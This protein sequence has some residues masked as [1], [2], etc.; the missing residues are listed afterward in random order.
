MLEKN[1]NI[2]SKTPDFI[3]EKTPVSKIPDE[4]KDYYAKYGYWKKG[5][6]FSVKTIKEIA[7]ILESGE[8]PTE[9]PMEYDENM[10]FDMLSPHYPLGRPDII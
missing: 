3:I 8:I 5:I 4:I 9:K 1:M 10:T 7:R 2:T 6:P